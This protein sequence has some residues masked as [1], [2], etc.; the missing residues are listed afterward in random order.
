RFVRWHSVG[1]F[2]SALENNG[3]ECLAFAEIDKYARQSYKAIYDTTD[4]KEYHDIT[5]ITD[6]EWATYKGKCDVI[7]GGSPCF[8]KGTLINTSEGL[9]EIENIKKGD[10][11]LTHK[12]RYKK[13]VVPM[14]NH[15]NDIYKLRVMNSLE[16]YVTPEHPIRVVEKIRT[17][18]SKKRKYNNTITEPK[19]IETNNIKKGVHYVQ[20]GN[21]KEK[22]NHKNI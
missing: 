15:S 21:N 13:V 6:E 7:C 19:M 17:Y 9:K 12:K 14:I 22:E 2:R 10:L 1:G 8:R 11:V 4:E 16:T 5:S 3:H 18:D 20:L